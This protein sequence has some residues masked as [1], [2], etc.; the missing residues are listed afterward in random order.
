MHK[1]ILFSI[2]SIAILFLAPTEAFACACCAEPGQYVIRVSKPDKLKFDLFAAMKFAN[3]V[4]L[5]QTAAGSDSIKGLGEIADNYVLSN[6]SFAGKQW[7]LNFK[8]DKGK[9]GSLTLPL[10]ATILEYKVDVHDK[11][12]GE[13][14]LYKELRFQGIA[15]NAGGFFKNGIVP[16]SNKYFFVLQGRGNACDN[17]EDYTHWRVEVTSGE[18]VRYAFFGEMA[19]GRKNKA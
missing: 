12:D 8:D 11:K 7:T 9:T 18:K 6:G 5:F 1:R 4:S 13:P 3:K 16:R 19:T 2:L 10:P 15:G 17:A 14:L